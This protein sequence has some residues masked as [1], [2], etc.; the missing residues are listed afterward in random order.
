MIHKRILLIDDADQSSILKKIQRRAKAKNINLDFDQFNAGGQRLPELFSADGNLDVSKVKQ[1]YKENYK[2]KHFDIVA[3]D[4]QLSVDNVNGVELLRQ[5]GNECFA[6][7]QRFLIYS[8]LL[9]SIIVENVVKTC[10]VSGGQIQVNQLLL[11]YIKHLVNAQYIGFV[12]RADLV[13]T[14][15]NHLL[16]HTSLENLLEEAVE[17]YPDLV[18]EYGFNHHLEGKKLKDCLNEIYSKETVRNDVMRD[19][20]EQTLAYLCN[21]MCRKQ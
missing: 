18:L 7:G 8:G 12:D 20:F 21:H 4:Y 5:M 19:L 14:I 17:K 11:K 3:C 13:E 6:N 9:E 2:G 16:D 1:Y 10:S 15:L